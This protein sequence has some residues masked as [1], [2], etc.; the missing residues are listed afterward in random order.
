[1]LSEINFIHAAA[2]I[3]EGMDIRRRPSLSVNH[4]FG[5]ITYRN[6]E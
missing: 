3:S 1:M 2:C 6:V 5:T 4:V